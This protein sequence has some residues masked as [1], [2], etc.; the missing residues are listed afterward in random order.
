[1]ADEGFLKG[2]EGSK[3][4]ASVL[5]DRGYDRGKHRFCVVLPAGVVSVGDTVRTDRGDFD[6][7]RLGRPYTADGADVSYVYLEVDAVAVGVPLARLTDEQIAQRAAARENASAG[8]KRWRAG[9]APGELQRLGKEAYAKYAA[10]TTPEERH[11]R[12]RAGVA[13]FWRIMRADP[14]TLT[15]AEAKRRTAAEARRKPRT[16]E[17]RARIAAGTRKGLAAKRAAKQHAAPTPEQVA[18][19]AAELARRMQGGKP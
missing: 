18:R 16:P 6:V 10:S 8:F 7:L 11:A 19:A 17:Q 5:I 12:A 14:A 1:M 2:L 9:L 13:E 4:P 15:P 3:Q